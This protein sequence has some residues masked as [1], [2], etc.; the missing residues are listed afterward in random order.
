[1]PYISPSSREKLDD[2]IEEAIR[3]I[4]A[5]DVHDNRHGYCRNVIKQIA[6]IVGTG[7]STTYI[8]SPHDSNIDRLAKVIHNDFIGTMRRGVLNYVF[9]RIIVGTF[10]T[11]YPMRARDWSYADIASVIG[12]FER[13]KLE[14]FGNGCSDLVLVALEAAKM[15][16]YCRIAVPKE[17][18]ARTSNTDIKEYLEPDV[19]P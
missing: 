12:V 15:E 18:A 4:R 11:H 17:R 2:R 16:F 13:T 6:R 1:M 10:L 3:S 14:L 8:Y 5:E 19:F 9:T 7:G